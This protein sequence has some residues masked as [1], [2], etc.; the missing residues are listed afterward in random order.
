MADK[1]WK[2]EER[3]VAHFLGGR[4]YAANT[5]GR[6]DVES[7]QYVAQCKNTKRLS[8]HEL[9]S[10]AL[11]MEQIGSEKEKVG[12]VVVKRRAGRG[13]PTPLLICMTEAVWER[14]L[15]RKEGP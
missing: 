7:D 6:V 1:A 9:E 13:A 15:E 3:E 2:H 4:R 10:L 11:E 8:L 14:L 5:G 12:V